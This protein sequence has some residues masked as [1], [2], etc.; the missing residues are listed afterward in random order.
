MSYIFLK[1]NKKLDVLPE[2][3]GFALPHVSKN[4]NFLIYF[5]LFYVGQ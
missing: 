3:W 4:V 5:Y 1:K 2:L